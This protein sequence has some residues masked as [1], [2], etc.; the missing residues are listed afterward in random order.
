VCRQFVE[1]KLV[2]W[3]LQ[4]TRRFLNSFSWSWGEFGGVW[5]TFWRLIARPW[6]GRTAD[7][8]RGSGLPL[9]RRAGRGAGTGTYPG[10]HRGRWCRSRWRACGFDGSSSGLTATV[11]FLAFCMVLISVVG[12]VLGTVCAG[13]GVASTLNSSV[14][15]LGGNFRQSG[16]G[17][18][19]VAGFGDLRWT[20][21]KNAVGDLQ[22][23]GRVEWSG[24]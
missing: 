10:F 21:R 24:F 12:L 23:D 22:G 18:A 16:S 20:G 11:M 6:R 13:L 15:P 5:P 1:G 4:D 9:R 7:G 8:H 3:V 2:R 17:R 19:G 14:R